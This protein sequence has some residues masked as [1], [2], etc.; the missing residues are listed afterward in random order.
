M[1]TGVL[2]V[3]ESKGLFDA[4]FLS[5]Y[6]LCRCFRSCRAVHRKRRHHHSNS[7]SAIVAHLVAKRESRESGSGRG[8]PGQPLANLTEKIQQLCHV[9]HQGK[10]PTKRQVIPSKM[11]CMINYFIRSKNLLK[12]NWNWDRTL[13]KPN[14]LTN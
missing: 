14:F 3:V 2:N 12:R 10:P 8:K 11:P 6:F 5:L 7:G 4:S 1:H 9:L 13:S